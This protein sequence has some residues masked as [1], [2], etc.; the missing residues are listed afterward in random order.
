M[1]R[2]GGPRRTR[3]E[4]GPN[5]R[6]RGLHSGGHDQNSWYFFNGACLTAGSAS[7]VEPSG[8]RQRSD[9]R[10][11]AIQSSYYKEPGDIVGGSRPST[12]PDPGG[13][14][15]LRFTNGYPGGYHQNGGILRPR[16]SLPARG[17]R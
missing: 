2:P 13:S 14:G 12:S 4:P 17:S 9:P 3:R 11:H 16:L 5:A 1:R 6:Q 8:Q 15:A 7:G 10:L